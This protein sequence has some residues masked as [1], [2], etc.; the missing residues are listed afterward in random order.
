MFRF[1]VVI[2][3]AIS[4]C[5]AYGKLNSYCSLCEDHTMCQF[6]GIGEACVDVGE[7]GVSEADKNQI[8]ET[9]NWYRR[10]IAGGHE[11]KGINGP[12]PKAANLMKF[13]WDEEL[14]AIAQRWAD[15]C[16]FQHDTCRHVSRWK[17][18]QNIYWNWR[19]PIIN[20]VNWTA[21]IASWYDEVEKFDA[22]KVKSYEFDP[23]TGHYTQMLWHSTHKIGCGRRNYGPNKIYVCNYGPAGNWIGEPMYAVGEPCSKCPSGTF[24]NENLCDFESNK[25]VRTNVITV[26]SNDVKETKPNSE[27]PPQP[28]QQLLLD[29]LTPPKKKA[30]NVFNNQAFKLEP[31]ITLNRIFQETKEI[32]PN[33]NR[34]SLL[35][36]G[37]TSTAARSMEEGTT[38]MIP[39]DFNIIEDLQLDEFDEDIRME[40]EDIKRRLNEVARKI[41]MRKKRKEL[42]LA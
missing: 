16:L 22:A 10:I 12:Q 35:E 11:S 14:A 2:I 39:L 31:K 17:V 34:F 4:L 25:G 40:I 42:G 32:Q 6:Q 20:N 26:P 5:G 15:Q 18:G 36:D 24:C 21:A 13:T 23:E 27:E 1:G 33:E 7:G 28:I 29:F 30:E 38:T 3:L 19:F 41:V 37:E 9:H 8:I